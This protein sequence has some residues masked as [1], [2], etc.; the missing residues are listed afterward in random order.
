MRIRDAV[1]DDALDVIELIGGVFAEY[2]HCVLD[3]DGEIP[4]LRRIA[5]WAREGDGAFWVIEDER[6]IIACGGYTRAHDDARAVEL[7]KLYVHRRERRRGLA[8]KLLARVLDAARARGASAVELWSD[9]RF[10][11]GHRF[12]ERHGFHKTGRERDLGDIS[13]TR[14]YHFV[15]SLEVGS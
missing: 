4:E 8:A 5:S 14:E 3:V 13:D 1:D 2:P 9:T 10:V 12:Y 11:D 7:K 15:R 6:R